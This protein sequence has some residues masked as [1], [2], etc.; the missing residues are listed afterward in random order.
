MAAPIAPQAMP[1]RAWV[2]HMSGLLSP[3][4][5]GS[6]A[7]V[8]TRTSSSTSSLVSLARRL[9]LP[10]WSFAVK[11]FVS[12]GTMNPRIEAAS[13]G[14]P[15]LAQMIATCA[16]DP[17]VI[18][19]LAPFSTHPSFVSRAVVIMPAGF[20][21][22]SGSV[23]PKHPIRSPLARAG[24]HSCFWASLPNAWIG[25][26]TRAP[27]TEQNERTPE[28]PRSSSCMMSPY[29]TLLSPAQPYRSGRLA[30]K[31]PSAASCGTIAF[32]KV[33]STYASPI[34]GSTS[35]STNRRTV[36]RTARSSSERSE[37]TS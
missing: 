26:M 3:P 27:C 36:S 14:A 28:S 34:T 33:P 11:P 1:Y 35:S 4:L 29:A 7:S 16:V 12:V 5:S 25:Y 2:R 22:W 18:H 15:V 9:S 10:F 32:G 6:S 19:I 24:S 21:P 17:L 8:G 37:S 31:K 20:E 13:S 30:P 23:S